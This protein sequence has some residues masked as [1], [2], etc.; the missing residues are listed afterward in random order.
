MREGEQRK[1]FSKDPAME[2]K[3]KG[4]EG[5]MQK[6]WRSR[7]LMVRNRNPRFEMGVSLV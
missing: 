7:F 2:L 3:Q 6:I 4:E 1:G 5:V